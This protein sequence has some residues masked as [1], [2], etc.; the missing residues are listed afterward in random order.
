LIKKGKV[1]KYRLVNIVTKVN[2][3]FFLYDNYETITDICR[4][5]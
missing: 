1:N 4:R 3:M 5:R 2:I